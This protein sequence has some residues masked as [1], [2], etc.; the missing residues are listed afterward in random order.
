MCV[1]NRLPVLVM[2][3]A[4]A[5]M[6]AGAM[7]D[8]IFLKF[9][10]DIVGD[11]EDPQH[12]NEI[13]VLSYSL[14]VTAES[15]WTK[16]G[17]AS[18]GKPNPGDLQFIAALNRSVPTIVKYITTG[19]AADTATL[20]I[21]TDRVGNRPGF[22]YAKYKFEDIFFTS[23]GQSLNGA[24]RAVSA[25]SFVYKTVQAQLFAPGNPVAVSCVR[26]DIPA[27]TSGKC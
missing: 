4:S 1:R 24:G 11:S 19:T 26:W 18:V 8:D 12:P 27:G 16:G 20:T 22:E 14:D 21:R 10:G 6:S 23:V 15:S 17:G 9:S 5:L 2:L 13:V 7:A 25:V 3:F